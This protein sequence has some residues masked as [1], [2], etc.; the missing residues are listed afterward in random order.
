[1]ASFVFKRKPIPEMFLGVDDITPEYE[2]TPC[3]NRLRGIWVYIGG[4]AH[5]L[6]VISTRSVIRSKQKKTAA[7]KRLTW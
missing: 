3:G 1:M 5:F 7:S 6:N 4:T 2:C